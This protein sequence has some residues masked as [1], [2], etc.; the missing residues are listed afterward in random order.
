MRGSGDES[1]RFTH[2]QL[3]NWRN[4]LR[5]EATL[6]RR[7]YLA[8]PSASG[9]TN[10]L[11]LFR[12]L[13][14]LV[15]PG[16]GFQE[17]VRKRG[18]LR[19]LR[20]LA[21]RQDSDIG[22][23]VH[24][25]AGG[26]PAGWEYELHFN[27]ESQPRPV[28]KR[29]RFLSSGREVLVR[30]DERDSAAPECLERTLLEQESSRDDL[31]ELAAFFRSIRYWHLAPQLVREPERPAVRE[32]DAFGGDLLDR[33]AA[34]PE[35]TCRARLRFI[36]ETLHD[37]VPRIEQL[38]VRR[39]ARGRPHL[40]ARHEHWR[41]RGAV[42]TEQQLPDGAL[43]L[44]GLLWTALEGGGPLLAEEPEISLHP[45]AVRLISGMLARLGR[46]SDRQLLMTTHSPDL[47]A[48]DSVRLSE[49]LLFL[50]EDEA[51][52]VRPVLSA[53]EVRT[54]LEE[55]FGEREERPAGSAADDENQIELFD[56]SGA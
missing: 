34:M 7:T 29:E 1:R 32:Q 25:G 54:M 51:T 37:A 3:K 30:P 33:M 36:L 12:F 56:P 38:D 11:D 23:L 45:Q 2:I 49:I 39:D 27:Q 22:I 35:K 40:R 10:F 20:C 55:G 26:D 24:A 15:T 9:K 52:I 53:A 6:E 47:V 4:F 44:I 42:Q 13:H 17:A 19:K 18:G 14:D 41:S 16:V 46:R 50:P 48:G 31:R 5:V 28:I 43:R 8:G 21:A